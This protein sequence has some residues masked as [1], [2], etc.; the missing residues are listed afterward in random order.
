[1]HCCFGL[2]HIGMVMVYY[3]SVLCQSMHVCVVYV[4][5]LLF[6]GVLL[7]FTCLC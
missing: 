2:L 4:L 6:G 1:M 5:C 3:I 7:V